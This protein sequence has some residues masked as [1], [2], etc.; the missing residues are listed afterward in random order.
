[1]KTSP[2][3]EDSGTSFGLKN[4]AWIRLRGIFASCAA[5]DEVL[6]YGSRAKGNFKPGSD[7]NLTL[8][9][10]HLD[11]K[12]LNKLSLEI[13][14][15][16]LPYTIDLSILRH[17]RNQDLLDHI[18]RVGKRSTAKARKRIEPSRASRR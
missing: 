16:L 1:M 14:E 17:I 18:G 7:I 2:N 4:S 6:L 9:G 15:L 8:K 3:D 13:D 5:V 11:L 12:Q 10:D